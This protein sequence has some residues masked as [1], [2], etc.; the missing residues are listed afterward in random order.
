MV[1]EAENP[2]GPFCI[3]LNMGTKQYSYERT[4]VPVPYSEIEHLFWNHES[5]LNGGMGA[6]IE[7]L[8]TSQIEPTLKRLG[9]VVIKDVANIK[10]RIYRHQPT[11][12]DAGRFCLLPLKSGGSQSREIDAWKRLIHLAFDIA[13]KDKRTLPDTIATIIE[14]RK[15]RTEAELNVNLIEILSRYETLSAVKNRLQVIR[16]GQ[17]YWD[18]FTQNFTDLHAQ[19]SDLMNLLCDV[20]Q[21]INQQGTAYFDARMQC[22]ANYSAVKETADHQCEQAASKN[23]QRKELKGAI[24][25]ITK[26]YE[27]I[28]KDS[29]DLSTAMHGYASMTPEEIAAALAEQVEEDLADIKA[30]KDDGEFRREFEQLTR[31]I[32]KGSQKVKDL[33]VLIEGAKPSLLDLDQISSPTADTLYSLNQEIFTGECPPLLEGNI[34]TIKRFAALFKE[35]EGSLTFLSSPTLVPVKHY[36]AGKLLQSRKDELASVQ[37][38]LIQQKRRASDL[39]NKTKMS[40]EQIESTIAAK[41]AQ[42]ERDERNIAL[43]KRHEFIEQEFVRLGREYREATEQFAI[44]EARCLELNLQLDEANRLVEQ[45]RTA[46]EAAKEREQSMLRWRS[47]VNDILH[48]RLEFLNTGYQRAERQD[49]V[50]TQELMDAIETRSQAISR[51]FNQIKLLVSDLLVAVALDDDAEHAHRSAISLET[52]THL[53]EKYRVLYGRLDMEESNHFNQVVQH[54]DDTMIQVQSI[55]HAR[56]LISTF[57]KEIENHLSSIKVSNLTAVAI[58]CKLHP[59]FDELLKTVDSVNLTGGELPPQVLYD[60][61]GKFCTEFVESDQRRDATLNMARL[62]VSVDYRVKLQG[63]DEF[64]VEAQSTGTSVMINCR[65]LAFLLKELLQADTKVSLPLFIDE[66]SNLDDRNLRSARD[67]A[68]ADGFCV[69]GATPGLTSGISKVL[70]NYMNLD[71]FNATDQSY[72][73]N[74]T[75]LYTGVS[76]SLIALECREAV[77]PALAAEIEA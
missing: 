37:K 66:L 14:G 67:I 63:S 5:S 22:F 48:S 23:T 24:G 8:S 9:A 20:E 50:V 47:T 69:F 12:P 44:L 38:R 70:G 1:L 49:V 60:R 16:N 28:K 64:T 53:H 42:I 36:D 6:P 43:L 29:I 19:S 72:S 75:I 73:P 18:R 11:R 25:E 34:E 55:R 51:S 68:D 21:G 76:E 39:A 4:A 57:I 40:V 52:L 27:R 17:P 41:Q 56:T 59:Q 58:E 7:G 30:L 13:A 15:D 26:N 45:A 62:I 2:H 33:E 71:Y 3:I 61:L 77:E 46:L 54:N 32:N 35:E 74:R 65:L 31:E 10:E